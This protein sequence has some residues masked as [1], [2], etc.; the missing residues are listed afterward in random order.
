MNKAASAAQGFVAALA[1]ALVASGVI[2]HETVS[3][4]QPVIVAAIAFAA[5]VGIHSVRPP[6]Q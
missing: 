6:K 3:V 5:A 1:S 4:W 2:N